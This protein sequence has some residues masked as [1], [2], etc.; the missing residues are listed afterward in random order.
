[1]LVRVCGFYVMSAA[2]DIL[3]HAVTTDPDKYKVIFE[4]DR[5]RVIDYKDKPGDKT[6]L[7]HH[8][9]AVLYMLSAFKRKLTFDNGKSV[10]VDI[11]GG[12]VVWNDEQ[13]HIGE[14]VGETNTHVL[15][16]ELKQPRPK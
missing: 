13:S 9:D 15:F 1:M 7:H 6:K 16:V 12:E 5:V 8:P 4:N 3:P 14:N 2:R 10:V 11:K